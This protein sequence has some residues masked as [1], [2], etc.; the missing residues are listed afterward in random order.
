MNERN[1][2]IIIYYINVTRV[3]S[4]NNSYSIVQYYIYYFPHPSH[5]LL[6][7]NRAHSGRLRIASDLRSNPIK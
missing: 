5:P 7:I 2:Y 4:S 1:D 3:K 6:E